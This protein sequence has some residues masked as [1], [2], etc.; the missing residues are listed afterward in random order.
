MEVEKT[1]TSGFLISDR[2]VNGD[3]FKMRFMDYSKR[4]AIRRFKFEFKA[5]N[6]QLKGV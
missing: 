2:D 4:E 6:N 1:I 5:H 3:L